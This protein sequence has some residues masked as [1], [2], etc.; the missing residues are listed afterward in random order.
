[1]PYRHHIVLLGLILHWLLFPFRAVAT[2][3]TVT[4]NDMYAKIEAADPGDQVLIAPGTYA[5]R[6][7]LTKHATVANPIVIQALDPLHP[8]VWD[9]GTNPVENATG[10]HTAGDRGRGGWQLSGAQNYRIRGI[11]FRHC[12]NA[13]GNSAAIRYYN[14]TTNLHLQDCLFEWNDNGLTGGTQDSQ[15]TV[16][17]CEFS[18]NGNTNA[19]APTHNIYV[20]GGDLTL[21]YCYVHDS[22]QSENFHLR[23][24]KVTLEFNW[25][26]R[27][28]NYE[29]DLMTDDDLSGPGPFTQTMSLRGNIFVQ[30]RSPG[31]HSQVLVLFN[32]TQRTNLTLSVRLLY[33]TFVGADVDSA[34]LNLGN[35][36]GTRMTAEF[37]DN[38][39]YG[40]R[41]PLRI[42]NTSA[43]TVTGSHNWIQ[44]NADGNSLTGS[45]QT[46]SPGFC[47]VA[48][49]D[50]R[51]AQGSSSIGAADTSVLGLPAREYFQNEI[52]NC[53]SRIRNAARDLG[54]FESTS[55][56]APEPLPR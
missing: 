48:D 4:T 35:R 6:V 21:R 23:C 20:Y 33:N 26:A 38:I 54:A 40:T 27:A 13:D 30:N 9:F 32:D 52:N 42:E 1:M 11:I 24:R 16:E 14:G 28:N 17:G 25:F 51:L 36:D 55:T 29:G 18:A 43:A 10:S 12:R 15:A 7:H 47:N 22:V 2:I 56:N 5:F 34:F 44:T 49:G 39:I 3:I 46:A 41:T 37:S 31:N 50:Y 8:P 45:V 53:Q 19:S